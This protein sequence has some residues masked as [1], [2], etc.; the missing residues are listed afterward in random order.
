VISDTGFTQPLAG[1]IHSSL[2]AQEPAD[3]IGA[4][5][6]ISLVS[7]VFN[8]NVN[9]PGCGGATATAPIA[10]IPDLA[11][12]TTVTTEGS[13]GTLNAPYSL[14][15]VITFT[16]Q[17]GITAEFTALTTVTPAVA[18]PEPMSAALLASGL[19][20]LALIRRRRK[21]A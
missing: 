6:P 13:V 2:V 8:T 5:N 19:A 14:V 21:A 15:E 20:G 17:P 12:A 7:C 9:A 16:L 18:V 1:T 10:S 11:T 3:P 4:V